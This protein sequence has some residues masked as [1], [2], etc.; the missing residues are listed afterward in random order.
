M[1][2]N[3]NNRYKE[4]GKKHNMKID[5]SVVMGILREE[6][7]YKRDKIELD[8][9]EKITNEE[10]KM[11][12]KDR[13]PAEEEPSSVNR[14]GTEAMESVFPVRNAGGKRSRLPVFKELTR[15]K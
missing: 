9:K 4:L 2:D 7:E 3:L 14:P 11:L 13:R 1:E 8:Q 5:E 10:I 15:D 12:E 6:D